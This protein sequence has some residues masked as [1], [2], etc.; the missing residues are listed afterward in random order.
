MTVTMTPT[1]NCPVPSCCN[2]EGHLC[3]NCKAV[4]ID[5]ADYLPLPPSIVEEVTNQ[6]Y[7]GAGLGVT[8]IDPDTLPPAPS[9]ESI[10]FAEKER[11][12]VETQP[13]FVVNEP[14]DVLPLPRTTY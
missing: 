1:V 5:N 8:P 6:S 9:L 14:D 2:I 13:S 10:L 11:E 3:E 7:V 12:K 4:Q